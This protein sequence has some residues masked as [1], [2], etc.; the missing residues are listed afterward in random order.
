MQNEVCNIRIWGDI[1]SPK[2]VGTGQVFDISVSSFKGGMGTPYNK[3]EK[4][5]YCSPVIYR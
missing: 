3:G 1:I 2:L 5:M 4:F